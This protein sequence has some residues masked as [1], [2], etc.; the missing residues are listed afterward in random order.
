MVSHPTNDLTLDVTTGLADATRA[1][2]FV[3][4][5]LDA[6][7]CQ[8]L[9]AV[10]DNHLQLGHRFVRLDL[11]RLE[12]LDAA[13]LRTLVA[14][15][16]QFLAARGN[17]ILTNVGPLVLRLLSLSELDQALLIADGPTN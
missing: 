11:S 7:K 9:T 15:H 3:R 12:F 2:I 14:A 16:N 8:L 10:L 4:G 13:G 1:I 17:L 5:D 6:A